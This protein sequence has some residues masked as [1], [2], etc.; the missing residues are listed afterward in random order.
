MGFPNGWSAWGTQI[1]SLEPGWKAA[2]PTSEPLQQGWHRFWHSRVAELA[3]HSPG[4]GKDQAG[5]G[6]SSSAPLCG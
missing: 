5:R 3:Q 4:E 1:W 6:G 2:H